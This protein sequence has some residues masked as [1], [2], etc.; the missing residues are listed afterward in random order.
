MSQAADPTIVNKFKAGF[1]EC[2]KEVAHFHGIDPVVKSRLL[3]HLSNYLNGVKNNQ[4]E[5]QAQPVQ[6]VQIHMLPSSPPSS[7]DQD[8]QQ[9]PQQKQQQPPQHHHHHQQILQITPTNGY[10]LK[11]PNG[12]FTYVSP[13]QLTQA[14]NNVQ[15]PTLVPIPSR[16]SSTA[17]AASNTS[18]YDRLSRDTTNSPTSYAPP[19]PAN[20]YEAMDYQPTATPTIMTSPTTTATVRLQQSISPISMDDEQMSRSYS[21]VP[22]SL[23]MRKT[24]PQEEEER[25]WRPW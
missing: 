25:P 19:S 24:E 11:L 5:Y 20:S 6:Q 22:L 13:Q 10:Y 2:A 16:T 18:T 17:S 7:P 9:Q 4:H 3:Q 12:V 8:Q 15:L 23:V 1:S 21:P 14:T